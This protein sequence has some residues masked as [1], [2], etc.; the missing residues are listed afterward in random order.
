M[1][2]NLTFAITPLV[3][4]QI[5]SVLVDGI[6]HGVVSNYTF[7]NVIAPHT[8]SVSF[9]LVPDEPAN[10]LVHRYSFSEPGGTIVGDSVGG[11]SWNG[12]LPKGGTFVSGQLEFSSPRQQFASLP[13]GIVSSLSNITIMAWVNLNSTATWSRVFDFGNDTTTYMF[14]TPQIGGYMRFAITTNGNGAAEQQINC[15]TAMSMNSWHQV[16]VTLSSG[17]GILYLDGVAAG[18]NSNMTLNPTNLGNTANNYIGKSQWP[19]PYMDGLID[20]FR[21]YDMGLSAAEIAA[22]AALGPNQ[23]L[24]AACPRMSPVLSGADLSLSWPLDCAG[25][26]LQSCTNLMLRNWANV[27]SPVPQI[28]WGQWQVMLPQSDGTA[29]YR[30][31]K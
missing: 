1:G 11:Y 8:I 21:I 30:L 14:L 19:D 24:S 13:V 20:E 29:F 2:T 10:G 28:V 23:Q 4:Y 9:E 6:S 26:T 15:S 18:T 16:A 3:N 7:S 25:Y 27:T 5:A 31:V 12:T 17:K 22:A